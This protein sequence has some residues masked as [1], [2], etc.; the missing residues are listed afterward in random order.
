MREL[1]GSNDDLHNLLL[2][3]D[4][5]IVIVGL[6][7][8]IRRFTLTAEKL[9]N[10]LPTDIGRSAAQLDAFVGGVGIEQ[11]ITDV[12]KDLATVEREVQAVDGRWYALRIIPYRTLDLMIRGAV[13]SLADIDLAKRSSDLSA[14]VTEYA[15]EGLAAIQHPLMIVDDDCRVI[16][17]NEPYYAAFQ[18]SPTEVI[19]MHLDKIAGGA[20]SDPA[21][22][23]RI[24]ETMETGGPFRDHAL[25]V[26]LE[27][28]GATPITINGSRLRNVTHATKLVL[29]AVAGSG[30]VGRSPE[31]RP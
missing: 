18:L 23:K 13:I 9:L 12:I 11:V 30:A 14:A 15:A 7:L 8:R 31:G 17:V 29:L 19:G 26:E 4:R 16:W 10:L 20:W 1:S 24:G 21:L 28:R 3:V 5:A 27:G 2:G 25:T 22:E 6:D